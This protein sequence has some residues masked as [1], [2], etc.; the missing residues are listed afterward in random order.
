MKTLIALSAVVALLASC[1]SERKQ[2][3]PPDAIRIGWRLDLIDPVVVAPLLS[4]ACELGAAGSGKATIGGPGRPAFK[5]GPFAIS[6]QEPGRVDIRVP[7]STLGPDGAPVRTQVVS[8]PLELSR[9][10]L[11]PVWGDDGRLVL[12]SISVDDRA[13]GG[14]AHR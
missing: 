9:P 1:A 2:T 8:A 12:L 10:T 14:G 4:G 6:R 7:V 3:D 13:G 5:V 11:L